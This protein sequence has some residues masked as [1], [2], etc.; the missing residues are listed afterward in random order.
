MPS[1]SFWRNWSRMGNV[2]PILR[3]LPSFGFGAA[4][5]GS[6]VA[7]AWPPAAPPPLAL[8]LVAAV[9][10][11]PAR[12][13]DTARAMPATLS[14][15]FIAAFPLYCDRARSA[16]GCGQPKRGLLPS[17][18]HVPITSLSPVHR[19]YCLNNSLSRQTNKFEAQSVSRLHNEPPDRVSSPAHE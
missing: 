8:G 10:P 11:Q 4:T 7:A 12:T 14:L 1:A 9:V 3:R 2:T 17:S 19:R 15:C 5:D 6:Y 13:V 16:Y 18:A